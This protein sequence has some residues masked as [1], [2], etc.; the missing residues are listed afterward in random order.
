MSTG[1]GQRKRVQINRNTKSCEGYRNILPPSSASFKCCVRRFVLDSVE[2]QPINVTGLVV[3]FPERN[4][5]PFGL[6]EY[7]LVLLLRFKSSVSDSYSVV[8]PPGHAQHAA[9]VQ[10]YELVAE[11]WEA[12]QRRRN[13]ALT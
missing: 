9:T 3:V 1:H 10:H 13:R 6:M 7:P 8:K 11:I 5:L 12:Y 4:R 2:P